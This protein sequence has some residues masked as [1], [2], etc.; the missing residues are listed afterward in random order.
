MLNP[1]GPAD[2]A[3]VLDSLG[4]QAAPNASKEHLGGGTQRVVTMEVAWIA[5]KRLASLA[6]EPFWSRFR[7]TAFLDHTGASCGRKARC[8]AAIGMRG[9][10]V[11]WG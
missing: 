8:R 11:H 2:A 4:K 1:F 3:L 10:G 6:E 9:N 5:T 7:G